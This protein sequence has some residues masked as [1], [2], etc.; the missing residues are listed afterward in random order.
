MLKIILPVLLLTGYANAKMTENF[1]FIGISVTSEEIDIQSDNGIRKTGI[2]LRYGQQSQEWRTTFSVGY[3]PN[4]YNSFA[5]EADKI[6]M[7]NMFGTAKIRPYLGASVGYM[8][9]DDTLLSASNET[10]GFFYGGNFGFILYASDSMDVDIGYHY[11]KTT[12][13]DEINKL[14]GIALSLHYFY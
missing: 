10:N 4:A 2:E 5:V 13:F 12:G 3:H 11:Y 1:P 8:R 7:D 14:Q 9:V 6:L